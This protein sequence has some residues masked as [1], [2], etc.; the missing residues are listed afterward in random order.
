MGNTPR[1]FSVKVE[2]L[3]IITRRRAAVRRRGGCF[4][5]DS[6]R[7]VDYIGSDAVVS[8]IVLCGLMAFTP[9]ASGS[10]GADEE[11]GDGCSD[12]DDERDDK[13][14][15]PGLVRC[16]TS[17]LDEGVED[18]RH[19]KV[20]H[21]AAGITEAA[22][23]GV[24]GA[25]DVLVKETGRPDLAGDEAATQ[26]THEESESKEALGVGDSSG[27]H[28]W[29]RTSKKTACE[30][31]S[32]PEAI[33]KRSCNESDKEAKRAIS[34]DIWNYGNVVSIRSCES[35]NVG[36]RYIRLCEANVFLYGQRQL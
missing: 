15:A 18:G 22:C 28:C 4:L 13:G 3:F 16:E 35:D 17:G 7:D 21:T 9:F 5:G 23:E 33:T 20:G 6:S 30:G 2:L 34:R 19:E 29:D 31:F 24:G 26:N 27:A 10:V 25:D 14:D 11:E 32:R 8:K 1:P 36:V 12:N